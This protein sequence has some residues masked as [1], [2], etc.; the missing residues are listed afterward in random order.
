MKRLYI[1]FDGVV[2]DTIPVLYA[3][4]EASGADTSEEKEVA[5]FFST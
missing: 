4:L 5:R 1:D 2:L 3:A